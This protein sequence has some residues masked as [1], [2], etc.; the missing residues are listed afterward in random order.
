MA[1]EITNLTL[2]D[3]STGTVLGT[4]ATTV[5]VSSDASTFPRYGFVSSYD[6]GVNVQAVE[7]SLTDEAECDV[8]LQLIAS[9]RGALNGLM[10]EVLEG[11]IRG[12]LGKNVVDPNSEDARALEQVVDIVRTYLK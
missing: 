11:H 9:S 7:R 2:K 8:T 10:A 1:N 5:D 6:D 3:D 4:G 12:H